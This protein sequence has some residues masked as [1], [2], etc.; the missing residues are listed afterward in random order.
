MAKR[1]LDG[2]LL[3]KGFLAAGVHCGIK[4]RKGVLDLGIIYS[5]VPATA[6]A[7]F[8][9]NRVKAAPVKLSQKR[10]RRGR[11]QA[12]VVNSGNANA[13]T[14]RRGDKDARTMTRVTA[15]A[16]RMPEQE[17]LVCST[18]HIGTHLPME[19]IVPG[20]KKAAASLEQS[21][22]A[23]RD[24]SRAILTTDTR[25]KVARWTGII[26]HRRIR[27][28]GIVKGAA[29]ISP[30][31]ATMLAFL[32]TDLDIE[33]PAL[34]SALKA[35]VASTFNRILV[36]GHTSTNDTVIILA[37]GLA[38]NRKLT[39]KSRELR[40]FQE[41]LSEVCATL[42]RK[43]VE[44]AEGATKFI[45]VQV[46]GARTEAQAE[47]IAR[48]IAI[49]PL[50][51]A[52][53]YGADPNWGRIASAAGYAGVPFKEENLSVSLSGITVFKRG[54]PTLPKAGRLNRLM[55]RKNINFSVDLGMGKAHSLIWT[56]DLT[57][58]Y[59]SLNA[60]RHTYRLSQR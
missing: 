3:P 48:A 57:E 14:G 52:A 9:T 11:A 25:P 2:V 39:S 58:K 55:K 26:A 46:T 41:G 24:I 12:I 7:T 5:Q 23:S 8:T 44:D 38:G 21:P 56:S 17:V 1:P 34:K 59:I 33:A 27:L 13:A 35:A 49:S 60:K 18:G 51:K 45:E 50:V 53:V 37:N 20:I 43:I 16:L 15:G 32:T 47:R 22:K 4:P 29:M 28:G 10:V 19:K 40:K 36:E 31:M 42:A 6:A 30:Q 54:Q